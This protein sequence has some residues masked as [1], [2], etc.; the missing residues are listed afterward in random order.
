MTTK[1]NL[2]DWYLSKKFPSKV[3]TRR[4][5]LVE[6]PEQWQGM[7]PMYP[8]TLEQRANKKSL[9]NYQSRKKKLF[10][11]KETLEICSDELGL[12]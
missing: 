4:G 2:A 5:K 11:R 12:I 6:I 3:R 1:A 9:K 8:G 10:Y 7:I